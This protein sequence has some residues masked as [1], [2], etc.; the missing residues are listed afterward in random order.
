MADTSKEPPDKPETKE[1][2][3]V[4][5]GKRLN[6]KDLSW[7]WHL[8]EEGQNDGSRLKYEHGKVAIYGK[9]PFLKG[10][11]PGLVITVHRSLDDRSIFPGTATIRSPWKNLDD[12]A[13]WNATSRSIE[14]DAEAE[15]DAIKRLDRALP[16]NL[17]KPFREAY[18]RA[19]D[20]RKR[21]YILAWVIAEVTSFK[22]D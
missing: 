15:R 20:Q 21:N 3:M 5:L 19:G 2:L 18:N 13:Q 6:G 12:V 11:R 10:A 1:V 16:K 7:H 22:D 17:L 14:L 8:L 4:C 9:K